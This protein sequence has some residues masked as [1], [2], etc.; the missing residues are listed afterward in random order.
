[1]I[2]HGSPC[3]VKGT[4]V[5]TDVGYKNIEEIRIGDKVL[6]HKNKFED[7]TN[8]GSDGK[9]PIYKVETGGTLP[10][11]CTDNHPFYIRHKTKIWNNSL[12]K[13][14]YSFS[15][16]EKVRL[17]N[18]TKNNNYIGVPIIP[19]KETEFNTLSNET[20]WLLGRYV[21]DGCYYDKPRKDRPSSTKYTTISVGNNKIQDFE[22]HVKTYKYYIDDSR[23]GCKNYR[24]GVELT[25]IIIN[26]GF[27]KGSINKNIP[28]KI[29]QLPKD[30]LKIFLDGYM[31]GDGCKIKNTSIYQ[32]TTISRELAESL[33]LAIQK[34]YH[35]GCR[36]YHTKRPKKYMIENRTV[37]QNDTYMIRFDLN[38][39]K[40]LYLID[41]NC[42]W[43]PIKKI[44]N[45]NTIQTIYNITVNEDHT[46]TA[47][48]CY[49]GN[50]QD[51][52][53]AGLQKRRRQRLWY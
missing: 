34:V 14:E 7:V 24:F 31:S 37:N 2:T 19:N 20:L 48:N 49:V 10:I 12:R 41:T 53:A 21:A 35:I 6:T 52:S 22:N 23:K 25:N 1:M 44:S 5:L 27:N 42:I 50:C 33:V 9:K 43:Y 45:T 39:K 28:F 40:S 18:L 4:K 29:L 47:N 3:F 36:I 8:F 11:Y 38:P 16:P 51:F 17:Y 30:K 15:E 26:Y 32:A 46:Y 13:Y